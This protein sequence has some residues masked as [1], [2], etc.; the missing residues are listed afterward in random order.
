MRSA[1]RAFTAL[2]LVLIVSAASAQTITVH[3]A[4]CLSD[5]TGNLFYRLS[6]AGGKIL[7]NR[8]PQGDAEELVMLPRDGVTEQV[9]IRCPGRSIYN[10]FAVSGDGGRV[11]FAYSPG[12]HVHFLD[13]AGGNPRSIANVDPDGDVRQLILSND[14]GLAV[15]TA[16]R[17]KE[18]GQLVRVRTNLYVAATDGSKLSKITATP[19]FEKFISFALAADAK[20]LV[21]VDDPAKG[22]WIADVD[23]GNA[24]RLPVAPDGRRILNVFCNEAASKIYYHTVAADGVKLYQVDRGSLTITPVQSATDGLYEVSSDGSGIYLCQADPAQKGKG[25]WWK[26]NGTELTK[27]ITLSMPRHLGS[28]AWSADGG[29]MVWRDSAENGG[30]ATYVWRLTPQ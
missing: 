27:L 11:A 24:C 30:F 14:G 28:W 22:P 9:W 19:V 17:F 5:P 21:W 20:T 13:Q 7:I 12:G 16:S 8:S 26:W 6:A 23:G 25:A 29:T 1:S 18:N 2:I 15:F 3:N 10:R 4:P